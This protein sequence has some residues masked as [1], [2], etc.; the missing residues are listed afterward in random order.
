MRRGTAIGLSLL[1]ATIVVVPLLWNMSGNQQPARYQSASQE[2]HY[3]LNTVHQDMKVTER[4]L[5][6]DTKQAMNRALNQW[7]SKDQNH[8]KMKMDRFREKYPHFVYTSWVNQSA[9]AHV[10]SG[11]IPETSQHDGKSTKEQIASYVR[12]AETSVT[13]KQPYRSPEI[14]LNG[15]QYVVEG[16]PSPATNGGIVTVVSQQVVYQV[17]NHQQRNLRVVPYPPEHK[18]R[19]K[20]VDTNT[21]K[22]V[23]VADGEDNQGTS[24]YYTDEIVVRFRQQPTEQ[25]LKRIRDDIRATAVKKVGNAYVFQSKWMETER[26]QQYFA[27]YNPIYVEPHYLYL[28]NDLKRSDG[29]PTSLHAAPLRDRFGRD[30]RLNQAPRANNTT[31]DEPND[32]LYRPYQ[33]NLPLIKTNNGWSL[34]KGREDV[35]VAVVDT[36]V[37]LKHSDLKDK[38]L[39][40]YN[41]INRNAQPQDDVGHGSH[42]AGIIGASVNNEEGIAGMTWYNKILPVKVLDSSGSGTSYSVAE[43]IIWAT[44]NGAKVINLSLGNY[45]DGALLH[46]AVRYAHERDVVLIAATGNDNTSQPGYPAAYPEVFAVSAT[47]S[48]TGKASY[49]NYG[50]YVDVVAPGTSIASTYTNNQYAA[51]SGTSMASPHVAALAALIRSVNPSL[52]NTEVYDIMRQTVNDLGTKGKDNYYG[53]GQI[54]VERALHLATQSTH[55]LSLYPQNVQRELKRVAA[56]FDR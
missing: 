53:H 2:K 44:D 51:L 5:S 1:G 25:Q 18:Y 24:H 8:I 26:L 34:T 49:S 45:V 4:L 32:V 22:D 41:A 31:N 52:K 30:N 19:V 14:R 48:N 55:S 39:P 35:I 23:T 15:K 54:D 28:T 27:S 38:L 33:W 10:R 7:P 13:N 3:K 12:R 17:H 11:S 56:E 21:K 9:G 16:Y 42:V 40:G 29:T 36:G 47:D 6:T 43:G 50:N 20:S 37:D 46:D